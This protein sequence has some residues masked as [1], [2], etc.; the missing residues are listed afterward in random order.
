MTTYDE[1]H[2]A[3]LVRPRP[4][5]DLGGWIAYLETGLKPGLP[6]M[7]TEQ[8]RA[9]FLDEQIDKLQRRGVIDAEMAAALTKHFASPTA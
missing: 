7:E 3:R 5:C 6:W 8:E 9:D 4:A 1:I 2:H